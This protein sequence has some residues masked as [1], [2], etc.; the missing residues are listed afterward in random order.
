MLIQRK[1]VLVVAVALRLD[2]RLGSMMPLS[3][4]SV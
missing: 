1:V 4:S 2:L 3:V